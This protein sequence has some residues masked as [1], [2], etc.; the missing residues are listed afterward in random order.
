MGSSTYPPGW[1]GGLVGGM[2]EGMF[3]RFTEGARRVVVLAQEEARLLQHN[4]IG[5]EHLLLGLTHLESGAVADA[6]GGYGVG[7]DDVRHQVFE[8]IGGGAREP[9]G[10]PPF[11]PRAKTVLELSLRESA[12]LGHSYIG[13]EHLLLGLLREGEG[14]GAAVLRKLGV[15]LDELRSTLVQAGGEPSEEKFSEVGTWRQPR[16]PPILGVLRGPQM[17][18]S[19]AL[20]AIVAV[21]VGWAVVFIDEP[22]SGWVTTTVILWGLGVVALGAALLAGST[23]RR[24]HRRALQFARWAAAAAVTLF[25]AG[26]VLLVI[27]TLLR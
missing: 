22:L 4:H 12:R 9:T 17:L 24:I 21:L 18:A 8:I 16:P 7:C 13:S 20:F 10:H 26:S 3:E 1:G 14:V 27:D 25:T 23:A 15:E 6:L 2:L 11:T 19:A 5:T